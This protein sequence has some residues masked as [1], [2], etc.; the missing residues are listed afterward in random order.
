[1][2]RQSTLN[3]AKR[4]PWDARDT[5]RRTTPDYKVYASPVDAFAEPG[6]RKVMGSVL[7]GSAA[8]RQIIQAPTPVRA[9]EFQKTTYSPVDKWNAFSDMLNNGMKIM[10]KWQDRKDQSGMDQATVDFGQGNT[11]DFEA[12]KAYQ[13]QYEALDGLA[14]L[15]DLEQG[16]KA[17]YDQL[18]LS[19]AT[20]D[21]KAE[22]LNDYRLGFLKG[23]SPDFIKA[24]LPG[25]LKIEEKYQNQTFEDNKKELE[26]GM[27][28]QVQ[29]IIRYQHE[30]VLQDEID[31]GRD[32]NEAIRAM[33]T[34]LQDI[35]AGKLDKDT[36]TSL[37]IDVITP[38]AVE[39][40]DVDMMKWID[41][42]DKEGVTIHDTK[43]W[44]TLDAG[45]QAAEDRRYTLDEKATR[46]DAR[47]R[48]EKKRNSLISL[49]QLAL[50][51]TEGTSDM[52]WGQ[53][54]QLADAEK[55]TLDGDY[56]KIVNNIKKWEAG[57]MIVTDPTVKERYNR[58]VMYGSHEDA[59]AFEKELSYLEDNNL[60][61]PADSLNAHKVAKSMSNDIMKQGRLEAKQYIQKQLPGILSKKPNMSVATSS[62]NDVADFMSGSTTKKQSMYLDYTIQ[63]KALAEFHNMVENRFHKKGPID[64]KTL[65]K[66]AAEV[67][68]KY[69]DDHAKVKPSQV[70]SDAPI[71]YSYAIKE[72]LK[73]NN[74]DI[75]Q[76]KAILSEQLN[77]TGMSN[78]DFY[79]HLE[80]DTGYRK[81]KVEQSSTKSTPE[82]AKKPTKPV[83]T[84]LTTGE[85]ERR[86]NP[87][88]FTTP[89]S[90]RVEQVGAAV[91]GGVAGLGR[92]LQKVVAGPTSTEEAEALRQTRK[93]F[94]AEMNEGK[95][96]LVGEEVVKKI[97][98]N[99]W[100]AA[101]KILTYNPDEEGK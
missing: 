12:G 49:N 34:N 18:T 29:K 27:K 38:L 94:I 44:K 36:I 100:D 22:A 63:K 69:S 87:M 89:V 71:S 53:L 99:A 46:S 74:G 6:K 10:G 37:A 73:N 101:K 20:P 88:E 79:K 52:T 4:T 39:A 26:D 67:I 58:M 85:K 61:S 96:T 24:I 65:D 66:M 92:K 45:L 35:Y 81:F 3:K 14:N 91:G 2:P 32:P 21:E 84:E 33:I 16:H 72:A 78:A 28:L 77:V 64:D 8:R 1:M 76:A 7:K 98:S 13:Q 86:R 95:D 23:R 19:G 41:I 30:E 51:I 93:A 83:K 31:S 17:L 80:N 11:R 90:K 5:H 55:L 57:G 97:F 9:E 43:Y 54:R 50:D 75:T 15:N 62:G 40:G 68:K 25:A 59:L 70:P 47:E 82:T 42:P 48:A 56:V 60:I